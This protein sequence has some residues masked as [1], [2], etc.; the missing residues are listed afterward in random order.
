MD[1]SIEQLIH[2]RHKKFN[3][4]LQAIKSRVNRMYLYDSL[5]VKEVY[6]KFINLKQEIY[7]IEYEADPSKYQWSFIFSLTTMS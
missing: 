5:A 2:Q 4:A 1:L 7:H 6:D 3:I